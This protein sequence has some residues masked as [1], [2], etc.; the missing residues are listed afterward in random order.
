MPENTSGFTQPARGPRPTKADIERARVEGFEE[1][2]QKG[3]VEI[4]DFLEYSY[5]R[6]PGRPDRGTPKAEAI[7]EL[8]AHAS[9]H[10][11]AK[12]SNRVRVK[13]KGRN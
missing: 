3:R 2:L 9:E 11:A 13:K 1:G 8:A 4:L 5:L 12:V 10:F 6:D 7:L